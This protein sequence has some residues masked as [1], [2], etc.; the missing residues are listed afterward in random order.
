MPRDLLRVDRSSVAAVQVL[1]HP[2]ILLPLQPAM[3]ARG[4]DVVYADVAVGRSAQHQRAIERIAPQV[5]SVS[6]MDGDIG[7]NQSLP[8]YVR[9]QD[10]LIGQLSEFVQFWSRVKTGRI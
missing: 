3:L 6:A 5:P 10:V 2:P 7:H 9:Q 8:R 4:E 1:Q